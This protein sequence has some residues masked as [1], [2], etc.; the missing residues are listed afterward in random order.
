M[1]GQGSVAGTED[2]LS[3]LLELTG[4]LDKAQVLHERLPPWLLKA[5]AAWLHE[6]QETHR[7]AQLYERE[8]KKLLRK[9][10]SLEAFCARLLTLALKE[11]FSLDLDVS[12]DSLWIT[13][14]KYELNTNKVPALWVVYS[15]IEKRSLLQA[16]MQNFSSDQ[17]EGKDLGHESSVRRGV[18]GVPVPELSAAAFAKCCRALDLGQRYQTYLQETLNLWVPVRDEWVS[19]PDAENICWLHLYE[20]RIDSHFAYQKNDISLQAHQMLLELTSMGTDL[21]EAKACAQ[22]IFYDGRP[23]TWESLEILDTCI[24]GALVLS[25]GPRELAN[26]KCLVYMPGDAHRRLFEYPSIDDFRVYLELKLQG[27]T[28]SLQFERY[29]AQPDRAAFRQAFASNRKLEQI[30]RKPIDAGLFQFFFNSFIGRLQID[31]RTLAVST[32]DFDA[33]QQRKLEERRLEIALAVAN[34]GGFFVPVLGQLMMGVAVG[35]LLG[36]VYEGVQDWREGDKTEALGHLFSVVENLAAMALFAAGGK[37][38]HSIRGTAITAPEFFEGFE[39]VQSRDGHTRLWKADLRPYRLRQARSAK[40]KEI[41]PANLRAEDDLYLKMD[42]SAY[43]ARFDKALDSWRIAHPGI[44]SRY[45]PPVKFNGRGWQHVHEHPAQW[46]HLPYAVRRLYPDTALI[47]DEQLEQICALTDTSLAHLQ[48]LA[49]RNQS[50]SARF[51]DMAQRYALDQNI[52]DFIWHMEQPGAASADAAM[53]QLHALPDLPG[54]PEKRFFKVFDEEDELVARYPEPPLLNEDDLSIHVT[55]AQLKAGE[56]LKVTAAGIY[57]SELDSLLGEPLAG[58]APEPLLARRMA[59]LLKE[60]SQSLFKRLYPTHDTLNT[61]RHTVL[62]QQYPDLPVAVLDELLAELSSVDRGHLRE[63]LRIPLTLAQRARK[64]QAEIRIDR[65]ISGLFLPAQFDDRTRELA[66][67]LLGQEPGWPRELRIEV[68]QDD[69]K[70]AVLDA[71]G[72]PSAL[73]R[74]LIVKNGS[75]YQALDAAGMPS[76]A[77]RRGMHAFYQTLL[78]TLSPAERSAMGIAGTTIED[79]ERLQISLST[80]AL[81]RAKCARILAREPAT[82][83]LEQPLCMVADEPVRV[84][85]K[86]PPRL[87]RKLKKLYPWFTDA[88]LGSRLAALGATHFERAIA[89]RQLQRK[90][91]KL[92]TEL[93]VWSND[94]VAMGKLPGWLEEYRAARQ[95]V[96]LRL[97]NCWRHQ[98]FLPGENGTPMPG[99]KLDGMR[100][101]SLPVF[102]GEVDFSHVQ[103]LSLQNMQ[104]GDDV[105]YFLKAF[106]KLNRLELDGNR[107]TRLPEVLSHMPTLHRLS[108][109]NNALSLNAQTVQ[110]LAHMDNLRALDLSDNPLG[111]TP[112]VSRMKALMALDLRNTRARDLPHGLLTLLRLE[113]MDMRENDIQNLPDELFAAPIALTEKINLRLNPLSVQ[114]QAKLAEYRDRSGVGMGYLEDEIS[115]L[116]DQRAREVWLAADTAE[117]YLAR[118]ATWQALKDDWR[119]SDFFKVFYQLVHSKDNR[120]VHQEMMRRVWTVLE[121]AAADDQLRGLLFSL[122]EGEPNCVDAAAFTFSEMEVSVMIDQAVHASGMTVPDDKTLIDLGRGLFRLDRLDTFADRFSERHNVVDRLGVRLAF[123][124]GLADSLALPGQ[125]KNILYTQVGG[126]SSEDLAEALADVTTGEMS[127]AVQAFLVRQ[128]FWRQHLKRKFASDFAAITQPLLARMEALAPDAA[129][130]QRDVHALQTDYREAREGQFARL[131]E[132]AL[133]Q[134]DVRSSALCPVR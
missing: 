23:V 49:E 122:A 118:A 79:A 121:A 2:R 91:V 11:Q 117:G 82:T 80:R 99:L 98:T 124:Q 34:L 93:N 64:A 37:V 33:D 131:T 119:S 92:Q 77:P 126:V 73:S 3:A 44:P 47:P 65:A 78:Q 70:G 54:W 45:R 68:V 7:N 16:A 69:L 59:R 43:L 114:S 94:E 30:K 108:L 125:P 22:G 14:V 32:A 51:G 113:S 20:L 9:V 105:G 134:Q 36:E 41:H 116:S 61:P 83:V 103:R 97:E 60:D 21:R 42:E 5:D 46:Q 48:Q 76:G 72:D 84:P 66:L 24:W 95:T 109:R 96:A 102:S 15:R 110:K 58:R 106:K 111:D 88:Q 115:L 10:E 112:D 27:K 29:L 18:E 101:G 53:L 35:E 38:I 87:L 63:T 28:Y 107:I 19:N 17:A 75:G 81:D 67:G 86:H 129:T 127:A 6:V 13:H 56:L 57:P 12:N 40:L 62:R 128:H 50:V 132:R 25:A 104:L 89:V 52:R 85:A 39:P 133:E 4:D 100:V 26:G 130:Y 71:V 31:A 90:L 120:L 123:R 74:R 8:V 55:Q 1:S